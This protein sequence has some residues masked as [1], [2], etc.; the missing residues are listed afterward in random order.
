VEKMIFM[1]DYGHLPPTLENLAEHEGKSIKYTT[2]SDIGIMKYLVPI[3]LCRMIGMEV[4][5]PALDDDVAILS[6]SFLNGYIPGSASFYVS[7]EY[8]EDTRLM[9][10]MTL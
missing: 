3:P 10:M 6:R 1:K 9:S 5:R 8:E 4:V 2:L 7:V